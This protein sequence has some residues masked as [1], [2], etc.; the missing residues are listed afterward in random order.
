MLFPDTFRFVMA[1]LSIYSHGRTVKDRRK[2]AELYRRE[3][4]DG[5][6]K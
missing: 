3:W 4:R 6:G 2:R 5:G 1:F